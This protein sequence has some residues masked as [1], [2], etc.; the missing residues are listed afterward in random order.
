MPRQIDNGSF[1]IFEKIGLAGYFA[2]WHAKK[3]CNSLPVRQQP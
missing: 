1:G 3:L 2:Y